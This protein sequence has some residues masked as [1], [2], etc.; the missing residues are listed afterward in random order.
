MDQGAHFHRCDFQVHTPR[1]TNWRG[2]R[3]QND[4]ERKA[5]AEGFVTA[6]RTRGLHAVAITDHHDI[7]FV[8][9]IRDAAQAEV[10]GNGDPIADHQRL[11]V[12]PGMELTLGVPCQAL[13]LLDADF[14]SDL[15][16][17]LYTVLACGVQDHSA[18][19]HAPTVRLDDITSLA[20]LC[21]MLDRQDHLRGHYILLPNVTESSGSSIIRRGFHAAYKAMPC[22]GGYVDGSMDGYGDGHKTIVNGRNRDY[23]FKAI[24]IAQTSDNRREDFDDL[25]K[26]SSWIKWA[27]PSAEA[28][29]QAC[30]A[31]S[32][33]ISHSQPLMP[34]VVIDSIDISNSRFMGPIQLEWNPQFNC[35]IGGRGT[36]KSTI[37]EYL[38]WALCDQPPAILDDEDL[39]NFQKKRISL[40]EKTLIPF[41]AVVTV[42]FTING[43]RHAVRRNSRTK[44]LLLKI[45]DQGFTPCIEDDV[46]SL[47]PLQAYSQKQLSAVGVRT[48]ELLRFVLASI[49]K[50]MS[51]FASKV[52]TLKTTVKA[53]Y[54]EVHKK[55]LVERELERDQVRISSL[56]K[57]LKILKGALVGVSPEDQLVL[58]EHDIY[59]KEE[60]A[61]QDWNREI[62][63]FSELVRN[64][65]REVTNLPSAVAEVDKL[66]NVEMIRQASGEVEAL[67]KAAK[68]HLAAISILLEQGGAGSHLEKVA[69]LR[70][71]WDSKF[72][73]HS[74]T[75]DAIKEK[76]TAQQAQ[77][78]LIETTEGDLK[79]ANEAISV[80]KQKLVT[81]GNPEVQYRNA[82]DGWAA[83]YKERADLIEER[84]AEL[85]KLSEGVIRATLR[86]GAGIES[87][88]KALTEIY[89]GT[90]VRGTKIE[91]L[92]HQIAD[93]ADSVAEWNRVLD[94][95]ES[96]AILEAQD[97]KMI[98]LPPTPTLTGIGFTKEE[99]ERLATQLKLDAWL[100][101]SLV[102]L[103]DEPTFEY[104]L[105]EVDY[106]S[107]ADASAGQQATAL[108]RVLLNQSGPPLIIDQP[109][110]DLDNPVI[111]QIVRLLWD[112]KQRRQIIF[113]S[114]NANIVVNGDADLVVCC[115]NRK[116]GDQTGGTIKCQGAIDVAAINQEITAVM[117]GGKEAFRLRKE[118]YGF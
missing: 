118:K 41:E 44:E 8:P 4:A 73:S 103:V 100:S 47:I 42:T 112:A 98:R 35:L 16:A 46:R 48:D 30:L 95:F 106:I 94:E 21:D 11:V 54:G 68:D 74:T 39:P 12:F 101:L 45:D 111:F 76:L 6:C 38:R 89:S 3:P 37:L 79:K 43:V 13:L 83:L 17:T 93:A 36:G 29:R 23:G 105:G 27:T 113:S 63:E 90:R 86:R 70:R 25:G 60:K 15:L 66:L 31:R 62:G 40:I 96:L 104:R 78:K 64:V 33:R 19:R 10:D 75:Y 110:E 7:C 32:T 9:Y 22:V 108:L 61:F 85:T 51:D 117:E 67:F 92:C 56:T 28:L 52:E 24:G 114:H 91:S 116:A 55:R 49:N 14:P 50:Q 1:D 71:G 80:N 69:E 18:D 65:R 59:A 2:T 53:A 84:C 57:Q 82:R 87:V 99:L 109:E 115:A 88:N 107:F 77:L 72:K 5:Y 97:G 34:G 26:H 20:D 58:K 102:E 81:I